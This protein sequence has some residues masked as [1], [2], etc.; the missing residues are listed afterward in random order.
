M[1]TSAKIGRLVT[2][3]VLVAAG[4]VATAGT[5]HADESPG[6]DDWSTGSAASVPTGNLADAFTEAANA[7]RQD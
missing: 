3:A 5:A 4:G 7:L 6:S 2:V 1:R